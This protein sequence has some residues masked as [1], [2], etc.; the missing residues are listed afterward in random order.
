VTVNKTVCLMSPS[1]YITL[2][3]Q[4]LVRVNH[5]KKEMSKRQLVDLKFYVVLCLGVASVD[6]LS[7]LQESRLSVC[8][9]I[10]L[11]DGQTDLPQTFRGSSMNVTECFR[12]KFE[13]I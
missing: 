5:L 7:A 8:V 11:R 1:R 3:Q 6:V 12:Q 10:F 2:R 9:P 4:L 13:K